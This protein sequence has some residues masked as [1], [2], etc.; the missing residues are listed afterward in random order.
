MNPNCAVS[1]DRIRALI[2]IGYGFA[3]DLPSQMSSP[4]LLTSVQAA[5]DCS[6][7]ARF[8]RLLRF[9][10][11]RDKS[12]FAHPNTSLVASLRPLT[13]EEDPPRCA[14]GTHNVA[15]ML[16]FEGN[17]REKTK[18]EQTLPLQFHCAPVHSEILTFTSFGTNHAS[19]PLPLY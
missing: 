15:P 6:N 2:E 5:A 13:L 14:Q 18:L 10:G 1:L 8:C 19:Q 7:C 9:C 12:E 4:A 17:R 11:G 16:S 3:I